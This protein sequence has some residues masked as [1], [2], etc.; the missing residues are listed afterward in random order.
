MKDWSI[1]LH[2][3]SWVQSLVPH[4]WP[5]NKANFKNLQLLRL[6]EGSPSSSVITRTCVRNSH[7]SFQVAFPRKISVS[8]DRFTVLVDSL[9]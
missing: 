7:L 5:T 9:S 6:V 3:E 2:V 1:C 8:C 4:V